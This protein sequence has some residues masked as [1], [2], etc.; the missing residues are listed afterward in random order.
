MSGDR[1]VELKKR[2]KKISL[3]TQEYTVFNDKEDV[4]TLLQV[5]FSFFLLTDF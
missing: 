1:V 3:N 2:E 4:C 5:S